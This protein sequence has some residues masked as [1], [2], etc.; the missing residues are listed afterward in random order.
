[1]GP[2]LGQTVK[3]T[4]YYFFTIDSVGLKP[5]FYLAERES[6]VF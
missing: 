1:M 2:I 5:V 6:A 4:D 3:G